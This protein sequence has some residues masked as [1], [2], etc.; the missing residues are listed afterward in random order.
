MQSVLGLLAHHTY[1][2]LFGWVL[3]EQGGLPIPSVPLMIAAGTLSAAHKLH[4]AY[5][6][7]V[8]LFACFISDSAWYFHPLPLL[9][10]GRDLCVA[11]PRHR[12]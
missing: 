3:I 1:S 8:I 7:P 5:A 10:R 11:H 2:L 9:P 4:V 12:R 6:I